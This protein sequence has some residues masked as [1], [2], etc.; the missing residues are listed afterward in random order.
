MSSDFYSRFANALVK[1]SLEGET[2]FYS[3][4]KQKQRLHVH[5]HDAWVFAFD[6]TLFIAAPAMV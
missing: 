5:G 2:G 4:D 1:Q 3:D 6:M